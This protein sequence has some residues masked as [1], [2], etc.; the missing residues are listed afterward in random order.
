MSRP[1]PLA[2]L[3]FWVSFLGGGSGMAA[4]LILPAWVDYQHAEQ[5]LVELLDHEGRLQTRSRE[6]QQQID[7]LQHDDAYLARVARREFGIRTPGVQT[8]RIELTESPGLDRSSTEAEVARGRADEAAGDE[9]S[10]RAG[11]L[12]VIAANLRAAADDPVAGL[13]GAVG[14]AVRRYP[15]MMVFVWGDARPLIFA[16]STGLVLTS[17]LLLCRPGGVEPAGGSR[18]AS[19]G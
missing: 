13:S 11:A 6:L 18:G 1:H 9:E 7:H 2:T 5:E 19:T 3:F 10:P 12:D 14:R 17:L 8:I 15:V 4:C 16:L